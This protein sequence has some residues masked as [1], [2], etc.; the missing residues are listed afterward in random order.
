MLWESVI[1]LDFMRLGEDNRG[2]CTDNLAG[3][4]RTIDAPLLSSPNFMPDALPAATLRIYP[5]L[6]QAPTIAYMEAI[7]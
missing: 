2:K 1:I 6:G 4:I 7:K 5:G 3:P